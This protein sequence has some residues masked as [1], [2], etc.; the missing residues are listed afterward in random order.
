MIRKNMKGFTLIELITVG[1]IFGVLAGGII[2]VANPREQFLKAN[3][4]R[5]KSDL[6]SIHR[7]LEAYFQDNGRYPQSTNNRIYTTT[8]INWGSS[9]QPYMNVLPK[10]PVGSR[11][12]AYYASVDGQSFVLYASLERGG[13]DPQACNGGNA[14]TS[15][16]NY[17]IP[18][19]ACGGTCNYAISSPNLTP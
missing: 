14:C 17:G 18:Q 5:R 9:W 13:K 3:D 15:L 10:D 1:A 4:A 16:A 7:S 19:R 12:Y 6:A 2:A 11:S 8:Q